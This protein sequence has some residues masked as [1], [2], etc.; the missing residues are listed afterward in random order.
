MDEERIIVRV[1]DVDIELRTVLNDYR[2]TEA[3]SIDDIQRV[4]T[5][6]RQIK[7]MGAINLTAI[8]EHEEV[9]SRY[10]FL[11]AQRE[12]LEKALETFG[13]Q[14]KRSTVLVAN[15]FGRPM[16]RSMRCFR[17]SIRGS[18]EVGRL[19]L[20][21]QMRRTFLSAGSTLLRNLQVKSS[22]T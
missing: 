2:E 22:R 9:K 3:P 10:E 8:E 15:A 14:F 6:D 4:E 18:L 19:G 1:S 17:R 16:I 21:S 12:D 7:S 11:N 5:L 13:A 20:N